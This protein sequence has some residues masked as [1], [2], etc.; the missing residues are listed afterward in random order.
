MAHDHNH[1]HGTH[2]IDQLCSVAVSG[3]LAMVAIVLFMQGSLTILR[4]EFRVV[5]LAGGILL[6]VIAVIRGVTL[7]QEVGKA[8]PA[9]KHDHH[10]HHEHGH[11]CGHDHHHH[12]HHDHGHVHGP[13]CDHDHEPKPAL[14]GISLPVV[15]ASPPAATPPVEPPKEDDHGHDHNHGWAP[16]R[17]AVLLL[18]IMLFFLGIPRSDTNPLSFNNLYNDS[19]VSRSQDLP[20]LLDVWVYGKEPKVPDLDLDFGEM[21]KGKRGKVT[22]V[23]F[24]ELAQAAADEAS[25][26]FF[27]GRTVSLKGQF[28]PLQ[29][30]RT[31]MLV[32]MKMTCCAADAI[33][34]EAIITCPQEI[35]DVK[36]LEWVEVTGVVSFKQPSGGGN[37]FAILQMDSQKQDLKQNVPPE[38]APVQ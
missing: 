35:R 6:L 5:V 18:P 23:E 11:A 10:H 36:S 24:K 38:S 8:K 21:S 9:H 32:R 4:E 30:K 28:R 16:I 2:Y 27:E 22:H 13:G 19:K 1:D 12:D 14:V 26:G 33:P 25:R 3:T 37:F 17:Y 15:T 31:F 20:S 29:N 7:W 34:L